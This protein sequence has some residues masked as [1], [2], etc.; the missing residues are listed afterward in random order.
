MERVT[1]APAPPWL[2]ARLSLMFFLELAV[3]GTYFPLLSLH[4][5]KTLALPAGQVALVYAMGP[6]MA[7]IAPPIVGSVADRLFSAERSLAVVGLLRAAALLL[8]ARATTFGEIVLAMTLLGVFAAPATVLSFA[9]AF[10][11][12]HDSRSIGRTRVW[13]TVSWICALWATSAY[14]QRFT[15][16]AAEL[17]HTPVL[18]QFAGLVSALG[19]L[20]ALSLPHTPPARRSE[21]ALAFVE[22]F[23]LLRDRSYRALVL[24][25]ALASA[26]LQFHYMLWPL[27]Y[28]D[29][30][31]GL[32]LTLASASRWSSVSQLL[33]LMLFPLLALMIR[34]FGLRNVFTL[35]L[36]AWPLRFLAYAVG[37]PAGLVMG[38]QALHGVN[39]VC[40]SIVAQVAIDRVAPRGARASSQALLVAATSGAGNLFG[41]LSCG[42]A[43]GAL[44]LPDGVA[45]P[46]IFALPL[47]LGLLGT[48]IVV[49][50]FYPSEAP[51]AAPARV[52][53]EVSDRPEPLG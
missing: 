18:F 40:G 20:Y 33:E 4:L 46:I 37:R 16:R 41:Q 44:T 19:A 45:W 24:S 14:L 23:G 7:L 21:S 28:T 43:L 13:G 27:F 5:S 8:A 39:V 35:G 42:A 34:R 9:V 22:A 36:L 12:V 30:K 32:G 49:A 25:A 52:I 47:A 3:T 10:H 48:W 38:V 2:A 15:G 50:N 1:A 11:H 17:A 31:N 6:L 51:E 29:E 26:C 53:A